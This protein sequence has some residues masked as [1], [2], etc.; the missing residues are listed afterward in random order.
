M[1]YQLTN[2]DLNTAIDAL[3]KQLIDQL[4]PSSAA[5]VEL[6]AKAANDQLKYNVINAVPFDN[7]VTFITT[8]VEWAAANHQKTVYFDFNFVFSWNSNMSGWADYLNGLNGATAYKNVE[9]DIYG[10]ALYNGQWGGSRVK[11]Q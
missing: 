11:Y 4:P 3:A 7:K 8:D 6:R 9:A 1:G 5:S 2:S 10:A